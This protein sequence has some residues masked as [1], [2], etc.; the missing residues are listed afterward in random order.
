MHER[1]GVI[2]IVGGS[3]VS[4]P[5]ALWLRA[6]MPSFLVWL[7]LGLSGAVVGAGALLVQRAVSPP[8]W[9]V[10]VAALGAGMPVH[11]RLVFGRFGPTAAS[12]A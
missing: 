11:A 7:V 5:V 8:E 1:L 3:V 6:R 9:V 2:L 10:T 4:V 12:V